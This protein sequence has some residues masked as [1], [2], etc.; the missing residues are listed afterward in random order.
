[1]SAIIYTNGNFQGIDD[2]GE[3]VANGTLI[4]N[5]YI[6]GSPAITYIDSLTT[7]PNPYEIPLS[8]S[9][10]ADVYLLG[11]E[12]EVILKDSDGFIVRTI[13]RFLPFLG[14]S[15]GTNYANREEFVSTDGQTEYTT[16]NIIKGT[17]SLFIDGLIKPS[18]FYSTNGNLITFLNPLSS[19]SNVIFDYNNKEYI[20]SSNIFLKGS[21]DGNN[22]LHLEYATLPSL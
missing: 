4:F 22:Y 2:N 19:G 17:S 12:Y 9:G 16:T 21:I 18:T 6:D 7:T 1:M 20:E 15:G 14:N 10:K 5:N 8:S 3:V 13:P 11:G